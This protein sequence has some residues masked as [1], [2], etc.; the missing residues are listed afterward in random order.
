MRLYAR[1][2]QKETLLETHARVALLRDGN[3]GEDTTEG[4]QGAKTRATVDRNLVLR[5]QTL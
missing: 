4:Q 1:S 3:W 2:A 5:T